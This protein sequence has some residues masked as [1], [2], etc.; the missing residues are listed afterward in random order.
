MPSTLRI[1]VVIGVAL[2]A[3]AAWALEGRKVANNN[4]ATPAHNGHQTPTREETAMQAM[5]RE[6][7]VDTDEGYGVTNRESRVICEQLR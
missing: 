3:G 5:C 7:L 4:T 2:V 6:I 1:F